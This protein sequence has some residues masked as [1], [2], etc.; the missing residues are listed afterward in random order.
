M[1]DSYIGTIIAWAPNFAPLNWAFCDGSLLQ[2][3]MYTALFSLLGTA[4]G[5]NGN[6]TFG[7]PDLRCRVPLGMSN[8]PNPPPPFTQQQLGNKGGAESVTLNVSQMPL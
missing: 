5:G 1:S 7:L 6:T 2:I 4:Y 8:T 3:N